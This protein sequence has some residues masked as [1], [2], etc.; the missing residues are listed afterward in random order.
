MN[1]DE[2]KFIDVLVKCNLYEIE[3]FTLRL[4]K[5]DELRMTFVQHE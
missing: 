2:Q 5:D 3:K 4:F 1:Y